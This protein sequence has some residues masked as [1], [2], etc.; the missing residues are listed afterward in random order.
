M[1]VKSLGIINTAF[2][3]CVDWTNQLLTAVDGNGVILAAFCITLVV[4]A[5]FMPLRGGNVVS[6]WDSVRDFN[7]GIIHK[8]KYESGSWKFGTR[9]KH[10]K[11]QFENGN[12]ASKLS[13]RGQH[14]RYY[15]GGSG[16][17]GI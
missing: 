16:K 7:V 14:L 5:L 1:V 2:S 6:S 8:G 15:A 11:G 12:N 9:S 4:G 3:A 17:Q 13:R 10:Y